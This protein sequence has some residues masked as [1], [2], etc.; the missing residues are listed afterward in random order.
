MLTHSTCVVYK[1]INSYLRKPSNKAL[2]LQW[3][4]DDIVIESGSRLVI[5]NLTINNSGLYYCMGSSAVGSTNE[6][7]SITVFPGT[8]F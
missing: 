3:V 2:L 1:F 6:S 7:I 4:Y 5:S 8:A